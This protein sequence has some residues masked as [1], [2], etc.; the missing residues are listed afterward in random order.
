MFLKKENSAFD[1]L[2]VGLG[3]PGLQ[4]AAT[5]HN[6]G[7]T[8]TDRLAQKFGCSLSR[9][10]HDAVFG[11]CAI[12][13]NRVLIAQPQTYMN[14]SGKAVAALSG[15]Y[16]IPNDRIIVLHDDVSLDVGRIRVRRKG[17]DGGQ[18]GMRDIIELLGTDEITRIKIGVGQKPHPDYDM[19]DWVLGKIPAESRADFEKAVERATEAAEEIIRNGVDS[20][21]NR[22]NG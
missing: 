10:R 22:Y 4:Y 6:A 8:A 20:A 5:R 18:K 1:W 9:H 11:E 16:K 12:A 17:S 2:I 21:M 14:L 13:G 7:F 19:K 3:N 15:F